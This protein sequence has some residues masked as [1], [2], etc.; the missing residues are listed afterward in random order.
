MQLFLFTY[1]WWNFFVSDFTDI[2][3]HSGSRHDREL[4]DIVKDELESLKFDDVSVETYRVLLSSSDTR[5]PNFIKIFK[6]GDTSQSIAT[7]GLGV[8]SKHQSHAS[9]F[10]A[11]SPSANVTV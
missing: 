10:V 7:E 2:A 8:S 11:Y 1:S 9:G 5:K 6:S 3:V 4:Q